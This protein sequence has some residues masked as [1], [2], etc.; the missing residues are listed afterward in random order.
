MNVIEAEASV[1]G[2]VLLDNDTIDLLPA[3]D[4]A[5]FF[6]PR[7]RA[8]HAAMIALRSAGKPI[9]T[10]TLEVEVAR[11]GMLDAI[12]G[13]AFLGGLALRVPTPDNAIEYAHIVLDRALLRRVAISLSQTTLDIKAQAMTG[14]E[15]L[16][17]AL[18]RLSHLDT[19]QPDGA[20]L[21]GEWIRK[22]AGELEALVDTDRIDGKP[23]LSGY[24]SGIADLDESTGG[25]QPGVVTV[26]AARPGMGKSSLGLGTAE[27]CSSS[28]IGVHVFS[29][30]D[31]D[32]AYSDRAL[33]RVSRV[34]ATKIRTANLNRADFA[35]LSPAMAALV[36][37]PRPW[38]LDPGSG[39]TAEELVRRVR[40]NRRRNGTKVVIV[41]YIQL[42]RWPSGCRSPHEALTW[43]ITILAD[44]AKQDGM[45]YVVLSQ[46]NRGLEHRDDKRPQLSDLRDSGSLEERSKCVIGLYRGAYYSDEP[47]H[48]DWQC[49][50]APG[51]KT[52]S[53]APSPEEWN[54]IA[55]VHILKN[56]NGPT[57]RVWARWDAA[58]MTLS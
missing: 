13:V 4:P 43:T 16:T 41:D 25:W 38:L 57:G 6:D 56:S 8:V 3:L 33:S 10:V 36:K 27:T 29:L 42:L 15:A 14:A 20:R 23:V 34:T 50:C 24:P 53:R 21:I 11:S 39:F 18:E 32:S 9:D 28:G 54:A 58:T 52:C 31:S 30:E 19:D 48:G 22:R 45:A 55:E 40:R 7:H 12:G 37:E 5:D 44:A 2:A 17:L 49:K 26:V 51:T 35:A 46:V 1:L 47:E